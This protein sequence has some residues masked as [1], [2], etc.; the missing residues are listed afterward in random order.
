LS[1]REIVGEFSSLQG[2]AATLPARSDVAEAV[3]VDAAAAVE[4]TIL[5]PC[6]NEAGTLATCI[7]K[8]MGFLSRSG[9]SG[10]VLVADNGSA[11]GSQDIPRSLGARVVDVESKGYGAA[12]LG[13]IEAARGRYVVMG[14]ADDS[15]DFADLAPF[16]AKLREGYDLVMGNRFRGGIKPGAMPWKNRYIG[17]P[18]LS[19]VGRLFYSSEIHDFHCGM[20]GFSREAIQRLRLRTT[21]ME[22]A[23]E[24]VVEAT[25]HG[26]RITEVPTTLSP[27]GRSRPPHLRPWRD[28]WRHLRFL[29]TYSP[30]WLF[31]YPGALL[32]TLGALGML[33]ITTHGSAT[34]GGI[35]FEVHTLVVAAMA[36]VLGVQ[37]LTFGL[38]AEQFG[39][40]EGLLPESVRLERALRAFSVERAATVGTACA[41]IGF[42]GLG[43]ATW[44]WS[45]HGFGNLDYRQTMRVVVPAV[46]LV[47]VGMQVV[48]AGFVSG[49]L[50]VARRP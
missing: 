45:A 46:T 43:A 6:L 22:F 49:M 44:L 36:F 34:L 8:A 24:M 11:D 1:R 33:A 15:Y 37:S 19:T 18:V 10:E 9:V 32:L 27:D 21:G 2:A 14:D 50:R 38:L 7:T 20:R 41:A 4:L 23:S 16:L 12:L 40:R 28:G 42:V 48:L 30:K 29:L 26:L 39:V 3:A 47:T 13:G 5:M 35:T 25:L 31:L 17:N